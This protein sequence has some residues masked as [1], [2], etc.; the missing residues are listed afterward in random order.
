[1]TKEEKIALLIDELEDIRC[2]DY[3]AD[4]DEDKTLK[5]AV[6]VIKALDHE[7]SNEMVNRK[8]FEQVMWERDVAIDQLKELGYEFGERVIT[9]SDIISRK[10]VKS[11]YKRQFESN[12]KDEV[13]GIDLSE[14]ADCTA[15]NKFI[16][17]IPSVNLRESKWIPVSNPNKELPKD[18]LLWVT[19]DIDGWLSVTTLYWDMTEWS[20][21]FV[22]H[23]LAYMDYVE[24]TPYRAESKDD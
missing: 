6:R 15:F 18:R 11:E 2:N 20:K 21:G 4:T 7:S 1:M 16:D 8:V 10:T 9:D 17:D 5:E 13:R 23:V 24:P 19:I 12:L 14:F 3:D 22:D